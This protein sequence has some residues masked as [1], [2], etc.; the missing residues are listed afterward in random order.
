MTHSAHLGMMVNDL[1]QLASSTDQVDLVV[2]QGAGFFDASVAAIG[3][4][5]V[6]DLARNISST[7]S[8]NFTKSLKFENRPADNN[9]V[10]QNVR[11]KIYSRSSRTPSTQSIPS[12]LRGKVFPC[13]QPHHIIHNSPVLTGLILFHFRAQLHDFGISVA[14]AFGSMVY[15]WQLYHTLQKNEKFLLRD[16]DDMDVAYTNLGG[17]RFHV[18]DAARKTLRSIVKSC[19]SI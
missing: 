3:T 14:N 12:T 19:T 6:I 13:R 10:L 18:S 17:S 15:T 9:Q 16:W 7:N 1:L 11:Q 2:L 8:W 5:T 4:N